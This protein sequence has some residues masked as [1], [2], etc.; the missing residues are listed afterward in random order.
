MS[1][2]WWDQ[3][4]QAPAG[5]TSHRLNCSSSTNSEYLDH[6]CFCHERIAAKLMIH[7]RKSA[8]RE[9]AGTSSQLS[10][11]SAL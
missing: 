2:Y 5:T 9:L 4:D 6:P 7:Q 1:E 11:L 3:S 10:V 8:S